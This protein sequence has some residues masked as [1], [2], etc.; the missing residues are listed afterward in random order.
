MFD[1]IQ[2]YHFVLKNGREFFGKVI[3]QDDQKIIIESD[4]SEKTT[5][6]VILYHDSLSLAEPMGWHQR[7]RLV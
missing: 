5:G 3:D 2:I 7:P 6:R 1:R 4:P